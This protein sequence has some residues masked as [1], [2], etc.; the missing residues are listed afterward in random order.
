MHDRVIHS[1]PYILVINDEEGMHLSIKRLLE[2]NN[3]NVKIAQ[4]AKEG[5]TILQNY[6]IDLI[7]CDIVMPDIGGLVM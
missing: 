1:L 2:K 6:K 3:F 5:L 4:S 7:I